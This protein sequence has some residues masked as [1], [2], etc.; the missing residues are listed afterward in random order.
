MIPDIGPKTD[1][2]PLDKQ[3]FAHIDDAQQ[4]ALAVDS[5]YR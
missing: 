4:A 3:R 5:L 2:G 1:N